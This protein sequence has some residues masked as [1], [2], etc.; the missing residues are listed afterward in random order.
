MNRFGER[1]P[2]LILVSG[3]SLV[4]KSTLAEFLRQHLSKFI[5][6]PV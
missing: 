6:K 3:M 2:L 4:G 1:P 5:H